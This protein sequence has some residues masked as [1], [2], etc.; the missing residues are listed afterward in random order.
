M[1]L[2]WLALFV[3]LQPTV[4][5]TNPTI[6][7]NDTCDMVRS[8]A[9]EWLHVITLQK[10]LLVISVTAN[11]N[12]WQQALGFVSCARVSNWLATPKA[13][14]IF[15]TPWIDPKPDTSATWLIPHVQIQV[16]RLWHFLAAI[17]NIK[18]YQKKTLSC[19][20]KQV[21]Q[22]RGCLFFYN[23]ILHNQY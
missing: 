2:K 5:F 17:T 21:T 1:V 9:N 6:N 19:A 7:P 13:F 8:S 20:E 3:H 15:K 11:S 10:M 4:K 12:K 16:H 14:R 23:N 18:V 22:R